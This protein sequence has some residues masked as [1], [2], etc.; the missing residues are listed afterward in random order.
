[1]NVLYSLAFVEEASRH[2]EPAVM[3]LASCEARSAAADVQR[4]LAVTTIEFGALDDSSAAWERYLQLVPGDDHGRR[5]RGYLA[6]RMGKLEQ[7]IA[8]WNGTL[9]GIRTIR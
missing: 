5:E 7:G 9:R 6:S 2:W 1:M 8:N 3:H 4:L